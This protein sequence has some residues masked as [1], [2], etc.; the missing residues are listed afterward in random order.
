MSYINRSSLL[1]RVD[2]LSNVDFFTPT[3]LYLGDFDGSLKILKEALQVKEEARSNDDEDQAKALSLLRYNLGSLQL[4]H[5]TELS[6][7]TGNEVNESIENFVKAK[8]LLVAIGYRND[9]PEILEIGKPTCC[10]LLTR[11]C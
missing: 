6:S 2:D 7:R 8:D 9:H 4:E 10:C 11:T 3:L 1:R 5:R